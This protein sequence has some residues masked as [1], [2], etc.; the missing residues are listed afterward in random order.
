MAGFFGLFDFTKEGPGVPKDAPPK[1]RIV[2]FFEVLGRKFW[3]I[4]KMNLL[5]GIFNI[6]AFIFLLFFA[7][8]V[9][10]LFLS[11]YNVTLSAEELSVSF[12]TVTV[13][14]MI[15]FVCL[16]LIT[17]GPAQAGMTYVLRNYSREEHAFLWWDFK[18]QALKNFKQSLIVSLINAAVTVIVFLDVYLYRQFSNV[19][20]MLITAATTFMVIAYI[21]FMMMSMYIYP[22]MVTFDLT[23]RQLY[24]NAFLFA[25]LK[26]FPNLLIL[27]VVFLLVF[28]SFYFSP[29]IGYLLF[30]FIL[31]GLTSFIT[32]FYVYSKIDKYMIQPAKKAEQDNGGNE[33]GTGEGESERVFS[34]SRVLSDNGSQENDNNS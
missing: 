23:I 18:E 27:I 14:L 1:P 3:N 4:V 15:Y 26:F 22:M 32:N 33:E 2:V 31:M 19:N 28:L 6:P 11:A 16:P 10:D 30:I 29:V 5:F 25:I 17:V 8:R 7:A 24:K 9:Q 20:P 13:P 12:F 21:I 34:D